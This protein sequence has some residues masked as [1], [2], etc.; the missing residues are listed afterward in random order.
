MEFPQFRQQRSLQSI[1]RQRGIASHAIGG[2][3]TK[4]AAP[5][6][7]TGRQGNDRFGGGAVVLPVVIVGW[8]DLAVIKGERGIPIGNRILIGNARHDGSE[9]RSLAAVNG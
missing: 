4:P 9:P 3:L 5:N 7:L 8:F 1:A 6:A 2:Y